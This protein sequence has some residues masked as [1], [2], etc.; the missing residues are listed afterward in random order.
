MKFTLLSVGH[1]TAPEH[2]LQR[3]GSHRHVR[4]P[5]LFALLE[6]PQ[7]GNILF[8]TGYSYRF[9]AATAQYPEK[10]YATI[11]PVT[12]NEA[13]EAKSQLARRGIA[14]EDIHHILISHF[15]ADHVGALRDF[16]GARFHYLPQAYEDI[17]GKRGIAALRR[18][19]LPALLP[20]DFEARGVPV[21]TGNVRPLPAEYAPFMQ[22][23]DLFGDESVMA[24]ELPGHAVGQMGVFVRTAT[25]TYFLVA[26]AC[27]Q[28]IAYRAYKLPHPIAY[29]LFPHPRL[30]NL[31]LRQLHQLHLHSPQYHI[32]PSHCEEAETR[33]GTSH[34]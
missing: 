12:L 31:T 29:L 15:H 5:A 16:P 3:G 14:A 10:L 2:I 19:F 4:L 8:D 18:A 21:P 27:W 1:C 23:V 22:G 11:T 17:K 13:E 34:L 9:F 24:V 26:D 32:I 30:Y 33:Y 6:H 7:H 28:S 20:P 25:D